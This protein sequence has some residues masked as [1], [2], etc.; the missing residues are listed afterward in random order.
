MGSARNG[1]SPVMWGRIKGETEKSV[2]ELG[3]RRLVVWRPTFIHSV[4][5]REK[6]TR[7]DQT[8]HALGFRFIPLLTCSTVDIAHAMLHTTFH[9]DEA[10]DRTHGPWNIGQ[11]AREYRRSR[12]RTL[13]PTKES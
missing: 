8:A 3:F 7:G 11:I 1:F 10:R 4:V 5:E 2:A 6:P 9:E 13:T 12:L